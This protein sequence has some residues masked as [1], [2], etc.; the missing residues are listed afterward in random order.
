MSAGRDTFIHS[1]IETL[2]WVNVF[3]DKVRYPEVSM[4]E[5]IKHDPGLVLLSS[6]PYPFKEKH[7]AEIKAVLPSVEV[8][9]VDGEMFS[10]YGS[11]M[12][13]AIDYFKGCLTD[14]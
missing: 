7:I 14:H 2:G 11:R 13:K 4:E 3:E 10:W 5:L 9:L 8:H 6:E 1:M 12:L